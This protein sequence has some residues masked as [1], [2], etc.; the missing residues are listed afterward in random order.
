MILRGSSYADA[1]MS[2]ITPKVFTISTA[3]QLIITALKGDKGWISTC[4]VSCWPVRYVV[5]SVFSLLDTGRLKLLLSLNAGAPLPFVTPG[6]PPATV[7]YC[8][9]SQLYSS[10][11]DRP[12]PI[13]TTLNCPPYPHIQGHYHHITPLYRLFKGRQCGASYTRLL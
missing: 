12:V 2:H 4:I 13:A 5:H 8:I 6:V 7:L 3:A 1:A 11:D 9:S 10:P